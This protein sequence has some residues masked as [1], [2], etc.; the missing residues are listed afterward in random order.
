MVT[1][2]LST[3]SHVIVCVRSKIEYAQEEVVE[4]GRRK[5]VVKKLGMAPQQDGTSG[6][7]TAQVLDATPAPQADPREGT[8]R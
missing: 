5:Q 7:G 8:T 2:I 3:A 6:R 4:S 1:G